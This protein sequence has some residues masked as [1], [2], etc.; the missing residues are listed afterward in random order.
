MTETI[1]DESV[2]TPEF[3]GVPETAPFYLLDRH[4]DERL[5]RDILYNVDPDFSPAL[6]DT[7]YRDLPGSSPAT[8]SFFPPSK[9]RINQLSLSFQNSSISI[10]PERVND[11]SIS[12]LAIDCLNKSKRS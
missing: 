4:I 7:E 10:S 9:I 5:F 3:I 2:I 1:G 11:G 12:V 8:I 6:Q